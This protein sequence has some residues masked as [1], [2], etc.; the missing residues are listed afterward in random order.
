MALRLRRGDKK[1]S[2]FERASDGSMTLMDHLR[3]LRSRLFKASLGLVVG[4]AIGVYFATPILDFINAPY[5]DFQEAQWLK[6]GN[7]GVFKCGFNAVSPIDTLLL[8]LRVGLFVGF[9]I[10]APVWLYQL[11]A[12]VAPGL[13][14]H[15]RKYTYRFAAVAGPLFIAGATLGYFVISKSL[16]FFLGL[17]SQYSLTVDINGYYDFV[18]NVMLLFGAGFEFPLLVVA[19]NLVGIASA[20]RLLGW[21][22]IAT[23]LVFVFCAVVTP[24]PDPFGMTALAIPMVGMYFAAVG[25]AFMHDKRK[26][27]RQAATW[28]EVDDDEASTIDDLG[29]GS[30]EHAS[31]VDDP[32][33]V[34]PAEPPKRYDGDAT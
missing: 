30:D 24:T 23:V 32:T 7:V 11:W 2:Q 31:T 13:H 17:S 9:I 18:T 25:F 22:R 3:E 1:K 6:D 4:L 33:P 12:F 10:S 26:A 19:L 8:N 27:K 14:R 15:E 16:Q 28:G 20:K 21:W 5:C 29:E 34:S